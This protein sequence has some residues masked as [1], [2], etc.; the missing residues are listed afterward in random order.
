MRRKEELELVHSQTRLLIQRIKKGYGR[1]P[2]ESARE[3]NKRLAKTWRAIEAIDAEAI[4]LAEAAG[5]VS[6][7]RWVL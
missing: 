5:A 2:K 6:N 4:P 7:S 1:Q 3:L